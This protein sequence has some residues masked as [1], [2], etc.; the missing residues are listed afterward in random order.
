LYSR[1]RRKIGLLTF[2]ISRDASRNYVHPDDYEQMLVAYVSG[3]A[4]GQPFTF[5]ARHFLIT[6]QRY[7]WFLVHFA[8]IRDDDGLIIRWC[9]A[10]ID[11]EERKQAEEKIRQSEAELLEAQRISHTG[12]WKHDLA[13][14]TVTITP[15]VI[16]IFDIQPEEDASTAEFFFDRIHPEDRPREASDYEQAALSK[17]DFETDYRIVLLDGSVRHVRNL[18]HPK[19]NEAG[20]LVELVGTVIDVTAAKEQKRRSS[21]ASGKRSSSSISRRSTSPYWDPMEIASITT[22]PPSTTTVLRSRP[23]RVPSYRT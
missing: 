22:A 23:G 19:L 18:G 4:S 13:S 1:R 11:I 14:G 20:D 7:H 16:R 3:A 12:S 9:A 6:D 2:R 17:A 21:K 15:E 8:P 5:E 10:G